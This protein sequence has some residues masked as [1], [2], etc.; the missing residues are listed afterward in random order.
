[1]NDKLSLM[2]RPR[3]FTMPSRYC[4]NLFFF[5]LVILLSACANAPTIAIPP[6]NTS[7][8]K[9]VAASTATPP[10]NPDSTEKPTQEIGFYWIKTASGGERIHPNSWTNIN[11]NKIQNHT[12]SYPIESVTGKDG[13]IWYM[14]PFGIIRQK[15]DGNQVL[16]SNDP[17]NAYGFPDGNDFRLITIGPDG[18]VWVGG[19]N[20]VLF[21]FNGE[22][23]VNEGKNL[24]N[25]PGKPD[26]LCYNKQI[27][28]FDFDQ[29][30]WLFYC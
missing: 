7:P 17:P 15:P 20:K 18:Q 3:Q 4:A 25:A 14:G 6:E 22:E 8:S 1:M 13:S 23:W 16:F 5:C 30:G 2:I 10:V 21:R 11:P 12:F 29:E 9:S 19:R 26:W 24:P 28:G 27:V